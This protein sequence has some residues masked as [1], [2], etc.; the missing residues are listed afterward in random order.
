[1][2][3]PSFHFHLLYVTNIL[4]LLLDNYTD[5]HIGISFNVF[6]ANIDKF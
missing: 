5:L 2:L 1:M 6:I 3:K 4:T